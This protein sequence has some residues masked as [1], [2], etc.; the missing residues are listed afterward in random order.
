MTR[1]RT[2]AELFAETLYELARKHGVVRDICSW[3][4]RTWEQTDPSGKKWQCGSS[5]LDEKTKRKWIAFAAELERL[6][7]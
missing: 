7:Q 5:A 1:L 6:V 2:S 3:D 4:A